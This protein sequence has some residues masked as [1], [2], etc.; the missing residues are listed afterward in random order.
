MASSSLIIFQRAK[1]QRGVLLISAGAIEDFF[2][3]LERVLERVLWDG[4]KFPYQIFFHLLYPLKL[5]TF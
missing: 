1:Y 2:P 4:I 5:A 3:V